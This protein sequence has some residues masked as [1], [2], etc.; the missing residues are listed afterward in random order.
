M[1]KPVKILSPAQQEVVTLST[2]LLEKTNMTNRQAYG[3]AGRWRKKYGYSLCYQTLSNMQN[4][5]GKMNPA[6]YITAILKKDYE[7]LN[8]ENNITIIPETIKMQWI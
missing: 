8:R 4:Q 5:K 1:D 2:F 6:S 7:F 3:C